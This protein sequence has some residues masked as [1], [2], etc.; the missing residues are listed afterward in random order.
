MDEDTSKSGG[1]LTRQLNVALSPEI[2]NLGP[3]DSWDTYFDIESCGGETCTPEN[4]KEVPFDGDGYPNNQ[5]PTGYTYTDFLVKY[6]KKANR[7][8]LQLNDETL[9]KKCDPD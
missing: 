5:S 2:Q 3:D 6:H 9:L 8:T 7:F 1:K 4:Y